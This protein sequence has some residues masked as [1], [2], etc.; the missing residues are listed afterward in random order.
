MTR[1]DFELIA[2]AVRYAGLGPRAVLQ[3]AESIASKLKEFNP[4]FNKDK[5]IA[6][7]GGNS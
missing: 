6:A 5:F 1:K 2:N 4:R 3:V 7:C